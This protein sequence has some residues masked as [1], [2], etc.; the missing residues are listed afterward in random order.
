MDATLTGDAGAA[1]AARGP[2]KEED[3]KQRE[4]RAVPGHNEHEED[5]KDV[6]E[7]AAFD[8]EGRHE[9]GGTKAVWKCEGSIE[10]DSCTLHAGM[11]SR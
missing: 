2:R 4:G 10:Y 5:Q 7:A 6:E 8:Q 1:G 9:R 11:W 3:R